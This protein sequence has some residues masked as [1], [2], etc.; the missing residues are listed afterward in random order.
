MTNPAASRQKGSAFEVAV[1][2]YLRVNGFDV[3]RLRL[4]GRDDEGDIVVRDGAV[5]ILELK[6]TRRLDTAGGI[7]E[8]MTEKVNYA[9]HRGLNQDDVTGALLWKVP[10]KGIGDALVILKLSEFFDI[11]DVKI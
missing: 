3:E 11:Q 2:K 7:R 4:A 9:R 8:A 1:M 10:G 6:A 5:T